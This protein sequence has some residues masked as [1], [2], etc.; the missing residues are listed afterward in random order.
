MKQKAPSLTDRH[1][2]SRI[3]LRRLQM[4]MSQE[5]LA[6][7][8]NLTFQQVQKYEKGTN[9]VSAG[10]LYDIATA[11]SVPLEFFYE[12][13]SASGE[14]ETDEV[15]KLA[16][17]MTLPDVVNLIQA[18]TRFRNPRILTLMSELVVAVTEE[19]AKDSPCPEG[20]TR[21]SAPGR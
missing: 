5:D 8:L 11:L 12:G 7:S 20:I 2:A 10:R 17:L 15:L 21:Q 1:V 18:L 9:R 16:Q 13:W 4:G 3:R 6:L 14:Q 19:I